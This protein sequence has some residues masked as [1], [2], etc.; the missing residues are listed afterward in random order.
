MVQEITTKSW[1]SRIISALWGVVFGIALVIG[2]F[3]LVFWNE[4]HGLHTAQS[5]EQAQT[6]LISVPNAPIDPNIN[7]K[8]VYFNGQATTENILH[9]NFFSLSENAISLD[10]KVEMYQWKENVETQTES[11]LGGSEQETKTY[12][13][14]P[15]WSTEIIDS[16][17]FK[18]P[19]GHQNPTQM[20][21]Q[22]FKQ[23]AENVKVGD[24]Q[25]PH[26]LITEIKG[27]TP[28]NLEKMNVAE[29]QKKLHKPVHIDNENIYA[30]DDSQSPKVGDLKIT[31]TESL[32]QTVSIIA[33]QT[34]NTLQPFIA[35]AGQ[36]VSLLEMGTQTPQVM[37]ANAISANAMMMWLLRFG[38]LIMMMI[39]LALLMNPIKILADFIPFL[40]SLVGFGTGLIA[41]LGGLLLWTC[42]LAIAWFV[43]RPLLAIG[44]VIIVIGICFGI[45]KLKKKSLNK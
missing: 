42:A 16:S 1:G 11:K 8:V 12:T 25:L 33:Q 6:V 19:N 15:V 26:D 41:F 35:P 36:S 21:I 22:S 14:K 38:S 17:E 30:G 10:R 9:D 7:M 32:P 31:L 27:Y 20:P 37:I 39:G 45:L 4:G 5:L 24:F 43:V 28:I 18:D 44:L 34:G 23:Y 3:V 40:G 13:Y 29:L 2:A